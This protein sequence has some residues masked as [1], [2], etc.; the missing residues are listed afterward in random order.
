MAA[1]I[2]KSGAYATRK[3][4]SFS[5]VLYCRSVDIVDL[6]SKLIV[7]VAV[8]AAS[9]LVTWLFGRWGLRQ[10]QVQ[11]IELATKRIAF[12]DAYLR[13]GRSATKP[14][15]EE[16]KTL[17]RDVN[18]AIQRVRVE[19]GQEFKRLSWSV[20]LSQERITPVELRGF[21]RARWVFYWFL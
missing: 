3:R 13:T 19:A 9:V 10:R 14:G 15:T 20:L 7:P 5:S 12:W 8:P 4:F 21:Q 2:W 1:S 6:A 17:E 11:I 16:R 18:S